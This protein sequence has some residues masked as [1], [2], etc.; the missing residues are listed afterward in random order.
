M[1]ETKRKLLAAAAPLIELAVAEDIGPG[2]A[3]SGATL[4]AGAVLYGR[5]VAKAAGV[6]AGLPVAEAVFQHIDPSIELI[7]HV[8]DGQEVAPGELVA[9][10]T[11]PARGL[12]AAERIVLNF[13][14][15]MSGIATLTRRFVDAVACTQATILDTRKTL[16]GF[17]VLDKYAV[18]MGG[19][20]NHRMAL[21]DMILIKDNHIDASGG[22]VP[23][24]RRARAAYPS[25]PLE[26]EVR[27][28]AELRE[29][30][31]ITPPVDRIMLDNMGLDEMRWAV[32]TAAGRAPLE[33]SGGVTLERAAEIAAT[34][35]DYI[36]V[37]ALTHSV[38]ALDLS[39]KTMRPEERGAIVDLSSRVAELK[40]E[41]AERVTILGHHY[42][43]DE[44]IACADFRG[45]SLKLARDATQTDAQVIVFCGVHFMA[46]TAAILS[47][48]GQHVLIPDLTAGCYLADT[49]DLQGVEMAWEHLDA[50]LGDAEAEFTPVTYVNSSAALKAFCGRHGGIVCTS[51]NADRVIRWALEQRPRV[52][53]FPDQHLGRNTA[54]RMGIPL[55]KM[56]L[57]DVHRPP[58]VE[59][60][61][62]ATVVL[63]PGACNVHLRFRAAHVRA[64]REQL[65]GI[66]VIVHPECKMEIVDLADDSGSTAHIIAQVRAAPAGSQWAIGTEARLVHRLQQEHPEQTIIP[67]ADV[68]PFCR[69]MSQITLQNLA[70]VLEALANGDLVN[71]VTV[72]AEMV[73]WAKRALDRMLAV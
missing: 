12:L 36:S 26:V 56:L 38:K 19:G 39:M 2:D 32:Q 33:A 37:G 61:R 35:V 7:A 63:W 14:Q 71:D 73:H 30:L 16:P 6:I 24:V 50:A 25:L 57:W 68:P 1:T 18:R 47:K 65:P 10:V 46:E 45:D 54:K 20:M 44:V 72:D 69:T 11:G 31:G 4:A 49:A 29:V 21:Y 60:I 41:L 15:R 5:I 66:R 34:G 8:A 52:F 42:Q 9:E 3:T 28:S 58:N 64:V 22:I 27:D 62:R 23:A 40:A 59:A 43:R 55:E 67:L 70:D 51:G 17:R 13:L 53:F 48:S